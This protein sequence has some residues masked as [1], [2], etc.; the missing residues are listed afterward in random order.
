MAEEQTGRFWLDK[1][2]A[3]IIKEYPEGEIVISSGISPSAHY[4]IGH[5]REIMTADALS[6]ALKAMGRKAKHIHLVDNFDPL[7]KR[8]EFLPVEYEQYVGHP[9]CLIPDLFGCNHSSY[10][11]H[12]YQEFA[13]GCEKMGVIP[14]EIK[15]SY[16]DLYLPG[17]MTPAIE[18]SLS[19][20]DRIKSILENISN[21]KLDDDWSPLQA[22]DEEGR[23]FNPDPGTW[24]NVAK[25]VGGVSY[26]PGGKVKL[27]WRLD[28]PARWQLLGVQVEPFGLQEHGA[29]G[30]SYATGKELAKKIFHI[31]PPLPSGSYG[32]VHLKGSAKKMSSSLGNLVRLDEALDIMPPEVLRYFMIRSVPEKKLYFDA[33]LGLYNLVEEFNGAQAAVLSGVNHPFREAYQFATSG[34][35]TNIISSVSFKHLVAVYQTAGCSAE[36]ALKILDR[37]AF[38]VEG[39]EE[40]LRNE[41]NYIDRWLAKYAPPEVKFSLQKDLPAT[42]LSES[43]KSLLADLAQELENTEQAVDGQTVH[44]MLYRLKDKYQLPT[45]EAFEAIYSILLGQAS[46]PKAGWF[47]ADLWQDNPTW[48]RERLRLKA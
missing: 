41:F 38:L 9:I 26:V 20:V 34:S 2:V 1:A 4:H 21:R 46:G 8:Y 15:R 7:R 6:W 25:S 5:F 48:L 32:H 35:T 36:A 43:Q 27:S 10:A 17:L 44:D 12:F 28:W 3:E 37:G 31:E 29:A 42:K 16:E 23:F 47:V 19:E 45:A 22:L 13:R 39:E 40:I 33:G 24:D 30:G 11:E 18:T 14:D